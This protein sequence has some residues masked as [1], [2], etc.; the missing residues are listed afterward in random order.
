MIPPGVGSG[1]YKAR[2]HVRDAIEHLY[3]AHEYLLEAK[4]NVSDTHPAHRGCGDLH[5]T[6]TV[7][8]RLVRELTEVTK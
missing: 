2:H 7:L 1:L 3:L 6:K 4:S 5:A 8:E